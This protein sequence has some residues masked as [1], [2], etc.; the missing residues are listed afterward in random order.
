[1]DF[2]AVQSGPG[3]DLQPGLYEEMLRL[4]RGQMAREQGP[5]TLTATALVHEAWLRVERGTERRWESRRHFFGAAAEAM[6][7]I[8][9]ERARRKLADKRGARAEHLPLD[10]VEVVADA[11]AEELLAVHEALDALTAEDA[12][13]GEIVR[14]RYFAALPWAEIAELTGLSER[15]LNRQWSYARAWLHAALSAPP[16]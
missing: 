11:P 13:A 4:A 5:Q 2:C 16:A 3:G 8:L 10:E 14:L 1:M 6:R 7:R 12:L 9:I 15:E